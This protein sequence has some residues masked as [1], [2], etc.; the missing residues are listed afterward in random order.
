MTL[1][2][3]VSG[4]IILN[5]MVN[6]IDQNGAAFKI[7]YWGAMPEHY[8]TLRH[9]HSFF[10]VCYVLEGEGVYLDGNHTYPLQG[11]TMFI[12]RPNV[13]HQLKSEKGLFLIHV[14]FEL[15][16]SESSQ[17]WIN[18][19]EDAKQCPKVIVQINEEYIAAMLWKSLFIQATK[20]EHPF[21]EE[22]LTNLAGNLII[23]LLETFV[24]LS[25]KGKQKSLIAP[26]SS[27]LLKQVKLHIR[28]NLSGS[29]KLTDVASHFHVS[30]RHLSR[31]FV[32][33]LGVSYSEFVQNERIQK[34]ASL[35][36]TTDLSI[37]DIAFESG[38]SSVHY[39][40]RVFASI[41]RD[42]PGRFR[43]LYTNLKTTEFT[44]Y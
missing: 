3:F 13:S 32:S 44:D 41:M 11:N 25:Q 28:D 26:S 36:K 33:E 39:F 2:N 30:S 43:S 17:E 20:A 9:K 22:T 27:P 4:K 29:L 1:I 21:F 24:P 31:I 34:A 35:L 15:I 6:R 40:T 5:Q 37:S 42:P 7:H 19:I 14:A 16:E 23:S 10:E 18:I 12:S 8:N 38:F